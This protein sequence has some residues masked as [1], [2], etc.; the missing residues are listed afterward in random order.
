MRKIAATS[1]VCFCAL[2]LVPATVLSGSA[3]A[4]STTIVAGR[5]NTLYQ[6][7]TGTLSDGAGQFFFSGTTAASAVRRGLLWFDLS[8]IP[9]GS[10][11]NSVTVTLHMS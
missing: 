11:I 1:V 7:P 10:T 4:D 9:T 2:E 6:D 3:R 8:S 5:D